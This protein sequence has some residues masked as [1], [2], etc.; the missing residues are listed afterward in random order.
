[1]T[2]TE[3]ERGIDAAAGRR[4][5][6]MAAAFEVFVEK[7]FEAA[8]TSEIVRRAKI[9]KR[10]LYEIFDSKQ[11]ILTALIRYGSLRM[12]TP[13]DLAPP[14][15]RAEFIATLH[16][17]GRTFLTEFL[18][19]DRMAMYRLAIAGRERGE[20]AVARELTAT[21]Q[22]PVVQSL[23]RYFDQAAGRGLF[24]RDQIATLIQIFFSVLIG[25]SPLQML[26]GNEPPMNAATID[27][28][29]ELAATT[30]LRLLPAE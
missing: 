10:T 17:F 19:P 22:A 24:P 2:K 25:F 23:V 18:H 9:S 7:G 4:E 30:L 21:G 11:A 8:T 29:A 20:G 5:A 14:A 3:I 13:P 27:A 16:D 1:M 12:Q 6:I 15:S 26:L 28:R